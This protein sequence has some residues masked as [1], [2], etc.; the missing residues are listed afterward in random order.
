MATAQDEKAELLHSYFSEI[1]GSEVSR[2]STV[3]LDSLNLAQYDLYALN[4]PFSE[5]E[6]WAVVKELAADQALMG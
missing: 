2:E 4:A 6:V 1:M 5:Q 3:N